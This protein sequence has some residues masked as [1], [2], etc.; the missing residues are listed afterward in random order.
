[1]IKEANTF[2]KKKRWVEPK[3]WPLSKGVIIFTRFTLNRRNEFFTVK[4]GRTSHIHSTPL[5]PLPGQGIGSSG[6][7]P[8]PHAR[9]SPSPPAWSSRNTG[10]RGTER[11]RNAPEDAHPETETQVPGAR[12]PV[13]GWQ[14]A[15]ARDQ[16]ER[17]SQ[18]AYWH[19]M[20]TQGN[21]TQQRASQGKT[22]SPSD[23]LP[24]TMWWV[25]GGTQQISWIVSCWFICEWSTPQGP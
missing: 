12:S 21:Q 14:A 22:S 4:E 1:M 17:V 3:L 11:P 10:N 23:P 25:V 9:L 2:G 24:D 20:R 6:Q 18:W 13:P 15:W 19:S 5:A 8:H 16:L 7:H